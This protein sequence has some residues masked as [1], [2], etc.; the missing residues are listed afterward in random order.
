MKA[1]HQR[2]VKRQHAKLL[3]AIKAL[4][5]MS[6]G[7]KHHYLQHAN[8]KFVN[9]LCKATREVRYMNIKLSPSLRRRIKKH[10]K[11]LKAFVNP[12]T[13]LKRKKQLLTQRGGIAPFLI[14]L[15]VAGIGAA[16]S[17][18]AAATSAAILK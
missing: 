18:G 16:G 14:P 17:V 1:R 7:Q 12:R 13:K 9:D 15:L 6:P 8:K 5:K 11:L 3:A 10:C 4:S 2:R